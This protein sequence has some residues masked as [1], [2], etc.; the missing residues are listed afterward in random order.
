MRGSTVATLRLLEICIF[1]GACETGGF[2][3]ELTL[4]IT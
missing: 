1:M 3:S 4:A 2:F